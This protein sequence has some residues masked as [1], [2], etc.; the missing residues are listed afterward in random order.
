MPQIMT[1]VRSTSSMKAS[2]STW[3]NQFTHE[4]TGNESWIW[5][6]LTFRSRQISSPAYS[7]AI[8]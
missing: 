4:G 5:S 7:V 8:T 2:A 3:L 6:K 1:T